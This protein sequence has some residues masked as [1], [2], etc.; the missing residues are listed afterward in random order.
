MV[1]PVFVLA[2]L[3]SGFEAA[4]TVPA[5]SQSD[6]GTLTSPG[7][8]KEKKKGKKNK[9]KKNKGEEG[10]SHTLKVPLWGNASMVGTLGGGGSY[11]SIVETKRGDGDCDDGEE[12]CAFIN[13]NNSASGFGYALTAGAA[14]PGLFGTRSMGAPSLMW[15]RHTMTLEG[16]KHPSSSQGTTLSQTT[17]SA[18]YDLTLNQYR[19]GLLIAGKVRKKDLLGAFWRLDIGYA[20]GAVST[21]LQSEPGVAYNGNVSGLVWNFSAGLTLSPSKRVHVTASPL[22]VTWMRLKPTDPDLFPFLV[23]DRARMVQLPLLVEVIIAI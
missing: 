13:N 23:D 3:L 18:S 21:T 1:V 17:D 22:G 4:A 15:S 5:A 10:E 12:D 2:S 11:S 9:G 20:T 19:A 16:Q 8:K 7:T 14:F 6:S